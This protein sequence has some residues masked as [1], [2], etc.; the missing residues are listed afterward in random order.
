LFGEVSILGELRA[1]A[2]GHVEIGLEA[3]IGIVRPTPLGG[4]GTVRC[5]L[6]EIRTSSTLSPFVLEPAQHGPA[7]VKI[8]PVQE[9]LY[10]GTILS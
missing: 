5:D 6:L 4:I 8:G 7:S 1:A 2:P 10:L 9:T 3:R